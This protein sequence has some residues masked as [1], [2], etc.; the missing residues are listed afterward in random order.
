[1]PL[2]AL[3]LSLL[4]SLA[5]IVRDCRRRTSVSPAVWVPTALM[6]ILCSRPA[7]LWLS[8]SGPRFNTNDAETSG[9]DQLFYLLILGCSL[10]IATMRGMRWGKLIANNRALML[11]YLYFAVSVAW[12]SDP[13]G[14]MKR[15]VKDFGLL[16][17]IA[18]IFTEKQP[19]EAMR[20]VYVRCAFLLL[21]LSIVFIKWFPALGR[22]YA[23]AGE[24][25]ATGVTTQKNSLGEIVLLFTLMMLWDYLE[26]R[27]PGT[28]FR[29]ARLPWD[30]GLLTACGVYLLHLS[31]SKTALLCTLVAAFLILRRGWLLR[32]I[33]SLG[34]L[35][36]AL[37]LPFIT[38]FSAQ[39]ASVIAPITRALGRNMTFTGRTNIWEHITASTVNPLIGSGY[40]NFWGSPRGIAIDYAMHT[41]VPNAHNGYVDIYLDGGILGLT[42]LFFTLLVCGLRLA[43]SIGPGVRLERYKK[44]R[45]AV[46]IA[47]IL[48]N[49]SES[50]FARMGPMWCSALLMLVSYPLAG[51]AVA[52]AAATL[53][54]VRSTANPAPVALAHR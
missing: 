2:I 50:T 14:S 28:K 46:L 43:R 38:Y 6:M 20:A 24:P 47:M 33:V 35:G 41:I 52:K 11:F 31:Q 40:W 10:L 30:L 19:L 34:I 4:F 9:V 48:Y 13:A 42:L 51:V 8:G 12:S 18:V 45:F 5:L 32:P 25:M 27:P 26:A 37:T 17:V 15:L 7:S 29:I 54:G 22:A 16:F 3:S 53:R 49:Q 21:P 36:C 1:M 23:I 44:V 39:F